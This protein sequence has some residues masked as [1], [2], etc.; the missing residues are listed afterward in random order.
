M[1]ENQQSVEQKEVSADLLER[2]EATINRIRP[3]IRQD[4]G[5]IQLVDFQ[6]G[7]VTVRM[8]GACAGCFMAST[9][10]SEGVQTIL[11]EEVPEVTKVVMEAETAAEGENP[12]YFWY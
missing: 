2:I 3:Y 5:D 1:S 8:I 12:G 4:G 11:M 10:I 7:V 6:D 9:D